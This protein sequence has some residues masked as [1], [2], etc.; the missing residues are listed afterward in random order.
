MLLKTF[1]LLLCF[2]CSLF[3]QGYG[4]PSMLSRGGNS[5]GQRGRLPVDFTYYGGMRGIIESGLTPVSLDE[6]GVPTS[7][8]RK[9]GQFEAGLYGGHQW[10]RSLLGVDYRGDYR[11]YNGGSRFNGTNQAISI[12]YEHRLSR[13]YTLFL[14]ETGGTSNRAFGGFSAP[15]FAS[16]DA[17]GLP[18]NEVFDSRIY[19]TQSSATLAYRLNARTSVAGSVDG[20]IMKRQSRALVGMQ[21]YRVNGQ[22]EHRLT[23]RDSVG[24]QYGFTN[25]TFP[26]IYGGSRVNTIGARYIRRVNR[27]LDLN[28]LVGAYRAYTFGT[29]SVELSEEV[30]AILGRSRGVEAFERVRYEPQ[31]QVNG[32]YL[33]ER[34]RATFGYTSGPG[35]GNGVYL[36]SHQQI[37]RA[38]YSYTG[39]RRA[40]LGASLGYSRTKSLGLTLGD[41]TTIQGGIGM[42]YRL[43]N[44]WNLS[45][46]LDR[47]SFNSP[48]VV[49]RSGLA[50]TF[51]FTISP[52]P[53]P[54]SIW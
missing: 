54:L 16:P 15:A 41:Y 18:T 53:L 46:Q 39:I 11:R 20:F 38:G 34:G 2:G 6:G 26:R 8:T 13:R 32:S 50:F 36:T 23:G 40:S 1:A 42:N 52:S 45:S 22:V 27:Y 3:G 7:L 12:N 24:V 37:Y 51:G 29:Q 5:P 30:A 47:R 17:P 10:R 21:G 31:I 9:G 35:G 25:F 28:I 4:G 48:S 44:H 14:S 33:L 43:T 49:G 19:F